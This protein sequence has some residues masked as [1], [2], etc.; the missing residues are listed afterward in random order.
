MSNQHDQDGFT[1]KTFFCVTARSVTFVKMDI[2]VE[3][4][5]R[6]IG[7]TQ[8]HSSV[9]SNNVRRNALRSELLLQNLATIIDCVT[10]RNQKI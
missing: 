7:N 5:G 10:R 8:L 6:K 4:E 9:V 1:R 2:P 3:H